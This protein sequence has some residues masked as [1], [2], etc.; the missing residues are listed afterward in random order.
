V[1]EIN[2]VAHVILSVSNWPACRRF[3]AQLLPFLGMTCTFDGEQMMYFVGGRTAIGISRCDPA[4]EHERFVQNS[5]GMHH[6]CL[7]VR[8]N[9]AVDAV[10]DF[11]HT[12]DAKIVHGPELGGWA[13]G[14]YSVLF[15][16]PI[17]TRLEINHVPGQGLL[18]AGVSF[19]PGTDYR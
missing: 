3:Y 10:H 5:V 8:D 11:L 2:G 12:L 1:V 9:A 14:Y 13:P 4:H 16:D 19:A 6:L 18:A 7:R 17:G 15:E